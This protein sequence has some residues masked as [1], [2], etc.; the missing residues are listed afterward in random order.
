MKIII[1]F[2]TILIFIQYTNALTA[3][4]TFGNFLRDLP[5]YHYSGGFDP[6]NVQYYESLVML[7]IPFFGLALISFLLWIVCG[8]FYCCSLCCKSSPNTSKGTMYALKISTSL[9][10]LVIVASSVLSIY[11]N[12]QL[13]NT[14]NHILDP[15][16][17]V[18]QAI[19]TDLDNMQPY[20][21][22]LN[23]TDENKRELDAIYK[24]INAS[25]DGL[26]F[27]Q[28]QSQSY[29]ADRM[30]GVCVL[31]GIAIWAGV[32]GLAGSLLVA[33]IILIA[34][35]IGL[36]AMPFTWMMTGFLLPLDT[37]FA[38][39]C[40]QA[41]TYIQTQTANF[42]LTWVDYF[43]SCKGQNPLLN[44]TQYAD[45]RLAEAEILLQYAIAHKWNQ[46]EINEIQQAV[47]ALDNVT[48]YLGDLGNCQ[49]TS[50]AW[51]QFYGYLCDDT[52]NQTL[53]ILI[54]AFVCSIF[55]LLLVCV[56]CTRR[57]SFDVE[58]NMKDGY[59]TL[60][61]PMYAIQR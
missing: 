23:A 57:K 19:K 53:E 11:G 40:P 52:F 61:E 24:L 31:F 3:S 30:I 49:R 56:V 21:P 17:N 7:G 50:T 10:S 25:A 55:L 29:E 15:L 39:A 4:D 45:F 47:Y 37:F 6:Q 35:V 54:G 1:F 27:A 44:V 9:I 42:N 41:E 22:I 34:A 43:F 26:N 51:V 12:V 58:R 46:S 38:D 14:A 33:K 28:Q 5:R 60:E 8:L 2:A 16:Q 36:L 48:Y 32:F 13:H 18:T 20:L 59:Q